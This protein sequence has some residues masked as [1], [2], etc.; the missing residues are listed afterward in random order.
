M[1]LLLDTNI[2][3]IYSRDNKI[4]KLIEDKYQ[5]FTGSHRLFISIV[6]LGEINAIIKKFNLGKRRTDKIKK[7]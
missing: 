6:T 3:V 2:I 5:I 4:S 7:S 1:D